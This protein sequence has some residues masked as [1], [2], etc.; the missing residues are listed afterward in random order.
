VLAA[1]LAAVVLHCRHEIAQTES[2]VTAH[3]QNYPHTALP[4]G[5]IF[6]PLSACLYRLGL[7]A[8]I[9]GASPS[10]RPNGDWSTAEVPERKCGTT[11]E[12][13]GHRE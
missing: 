13:E 9:G 5:P 1:G 7:P 11:V 3:L 10:E 2:V 12:T 4:H 6:Y 8:P